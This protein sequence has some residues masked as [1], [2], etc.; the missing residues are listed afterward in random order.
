MSVRVGLI[1]TGHIAQVHL[2]CLQELPGVQVVAVC[3]RFGAVAE[4]TAERF[5]IPH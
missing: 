3:D 4:M 2:E 5:G 1:G